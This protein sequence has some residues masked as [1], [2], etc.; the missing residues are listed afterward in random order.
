MNVD[1]ARLLIT[2]AASLQIHPRPVDADHLDDMARGWA[3][4]CEHVPY[5]F[6]HK[7]VINWEGP[8]NIRASQVR[9]GWEDHRIRPDSRQIYDDRACAFVRLC[10]CRHAPGECLRGYV[11][12]PRE[13]TIE[14]RGEVTNRDGSTVTIEREVIRDKWCE[15]CWDARNARRRELGKDPLD[16]GVVGPHQ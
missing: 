16:V 9:G 6:A 13:Y 10:R 7:M 4:V 12:V 14:P 8:Y 15:T 1:E 11:D 5:D 3:E 2:E